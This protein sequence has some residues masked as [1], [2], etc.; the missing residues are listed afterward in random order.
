MS[1]EAAATAAAAVVGGWGDLV[2]AIAFTFEVRTAKALENSIPAESDKNLN[3]DRTQKLTQ[4][5]D[6][7]L[8]RNDDFLCIF[9]ELFETVNTNTSEKS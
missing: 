9:G 1:D 8:L 2:V 3:V 4:K 7:Y 5:L 6:L